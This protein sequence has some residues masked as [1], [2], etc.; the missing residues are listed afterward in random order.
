M[1]GGLSKGRVCRPG[2]GNGQ[3]KRTKRWFPSLVEFYEGRLGKGMGSAGPGI[4]EFKEG[5]RC[6]AW[7]WMQPGGVRLSWHW[8]GGAL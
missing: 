4:Y 2:V 7:G 3:C 5:P 1:A 6:L 8:F